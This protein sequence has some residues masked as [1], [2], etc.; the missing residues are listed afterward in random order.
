M[1]YDMSVIDGIILK[2]RHVEIP[3]AL[4]RQ[5][6]EQLHV[7]HLVIVKSKLLTCESIYWTGMN[8]DIEKHIKICFTH[9]NLQQMQPKEKIIHHEI[10]GKP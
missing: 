2:D 1:T 5:A 3:E 7:N 6:L 4:Q 8:N 10:T 9:L